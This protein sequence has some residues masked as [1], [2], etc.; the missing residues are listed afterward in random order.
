MKGSNPPPS[1]TAFFPYATPSASNSLTSFLPG[2][3][4]AVSADRNCVDACAVLPVMA[5]TVAIAAPTSA[6]VIPIVAAIGVTWDM[7]AESSPIVVFPAFI[8]AN[9]MSD[10]SP[11]CSAPMP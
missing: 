1:V 3:A 6:K 5:V 2:A 10:I 4:I 11:A 8:V 9:I 7:F